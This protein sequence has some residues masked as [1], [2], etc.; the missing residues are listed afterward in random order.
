M[1]NVTIGDFPVRGTVLDNTYFATET[2][3]LTEK[4]LASSLKNYISS[5]TNIT[6]SG[7]INASGGLVA[8]SISAGTIGNTGAVITGTLSTSNQ[9][10]IT[11]VG[12]L[13]NLSVTDNILLN[14]A[15]VWSANASATFARINS[16][17][18]GDLTPSTARFTSIT[19]TGLVINGAMSASTGQFTTLTG[20][21]IRASGSFLPTANLLP[22]LGGTTN[23]FGEAYINTASIKTGRINVVNAV[24]VTATNMTATGTTT[25][26]TLLRPDANV[27][28]SIGSNTLRFTEIYG[29]TGHFYTLNG[30]TVN[31]TTVNGTTVAAT[32]VNATTSNVTNLNVTNV[33]VASTFEPTGNLSVNLG[34]TTKWFNTIYGRST[35]A[36]YA[37]LAENYASDTVYEPGT[38]VSFGGSAEIT[39]TTESHDPAVAGVISTNPAYLMNADASGL[40]VALSG[41]VPCKVQGPVSKGDR[42]VSAGH[43]VAKVLNPQEY[44]PGCVIGHS[45]ESHESSEVRMIEVVVMKF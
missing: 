20:T 25:I 30:T 23:W 21:N 3:G 18:I 8:S 44:V 28:A 32:T 2:A 14:G 11:K 5:L 43:G 10:N 16:T 29:A 1:T 17:P 37:D 19:G 24:T 9:P 4:I 26:G 31:S 39:V 45:L 33:D 7:I 22:K 13:Q 15:Q 6:T 38:V 35:Q 41:R 36:Q 34:S 42:L 27:S 12:V 40:P